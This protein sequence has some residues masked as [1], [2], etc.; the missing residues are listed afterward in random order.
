M[1]SAGKLLENLMVFVANSPAPQ[2]TR[3]VRTPLLD[4]PDSPESSSYKKVDLVVL[5]AAPAK[6]APVLAG[7]KRAAKAAPK[8]R[9]AEA[10]AAPK[11]R[12]AD[13]AEADQVDDAHREATAAASAGS[14]SSA[15]RRCFTSAAGR[16]GDA[17][18]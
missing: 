14:E 5:E 8:K 17:W 13:A 7:S 16:A 18:S 9:A 2:D 11:K 10:K 1:S 4:L 15:G 3:Q 6:R 12:A